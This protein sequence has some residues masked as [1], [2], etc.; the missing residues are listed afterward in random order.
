MRNHPSQSRKDFTLTQCFLTSPNRN[1]NMTYTNQL[2]SAGDM[3]E[4]LV[5]NLFKDLGNGKDNLM[6]AAVGIAGEAGE[7][8]DAVKKHWAYNKP[9]DLANV[10]EE[11]GD[12]EF[13]MRA[14]RTQLNVSRE[15]ILINNIEKL[16]KRYATGSYSD[17]Q[18]QD[19]ADK[20]EPTSPTNLIDLPEIRNSM[21]EDFN[22]SE[23]LAILNGE[24]L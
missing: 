8:L 7:L 17:Q 11:L 1:D 10:V 23:E 2:Q 15:Y 16:N 4:T 9:L 13:Y 18:A 24:R 22:K 21:L 3:H 20:L 14:L 5:K 12:L 19:R 6:H